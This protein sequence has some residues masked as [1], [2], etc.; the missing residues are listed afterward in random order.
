MKKYN[1]E[2]RPNFPK[3]AVITAGMPYG[4]KEL[5]F[6]HIGGVFIHADTFARFLR[7]RIGNENVIFVSGT[8]CYGSPILESYRKLMENDK[9][10][11][12]SIKDYVRKNHLHQKETLDRY[13]ISLNLYGASALDRPAEIHEEVSKDIFE[14]LYE[15]GCIEKMSTPQFYDREYDVLLNGRQVIGKCPIEGCNS[16]KG[17]A[18]EC[19]LGHQ[20]MPSEL[21]DPKSTLSGKTPEII[22]VENWYFKLE[23]YK[24]FLE[25]YVKEEREDSNTRKFILNIID[26]FLKQPV[27][28]V[29]KNQLTG[30]ESIIS[31]LPKHELIDEENKPSY[32]FIFDTLDDRDKAREVFAR[33]GVFI[34]TGKTLVPFRLSGNIEWGVKLPDKDGLKNLTFWV[35]P[36][37]LWAPISF[38]KAYLESNNKYDDEWKKW[39]MS[40]D[41]KVYQFIGEDN[42]YFYGIAEMAL[43]HGLDFKDEDGKTILPHLIANRHVLFLDKK[44]SSSG[45]IKPPMARELLDFYTPEQLRLHFLSLGLNN[46]S[47]SFNPQVYLPKEEQ[48]GMDVVLKDGNLLTNVFNRLVRSCFYTSAKYFDGIIPFGQVGSEMLNESENAILEY[49]RHMYNHEFHRIT[50]VLDSYVRYCNKYW[51]NQMRQADTTDNSELRKQVL[52]DCIHGV[53][54]A[55]LLFHPIAPVGCEK[56]REYL[57]IDERFWNWDYAFS[58]IYDLMPEEKN[59][60]IRELK[61]R[62]DFF[63]KHESQF[64]E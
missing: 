9:E 46:K 7:D 64:E 1:R 60:R 22:E 37:S 45:S 27:I 10:S 21:I 49:E 43:F 61:A 25:S 12:F 58:T 59:H 35:W 33:E 53:K 38:T 56:I 57:N 26:E 31:Q 48:A 4:N 5:H 15:K 55:A 29:K 42:I 63:V 23:E 8:D 11:S 41:S 2:S 39:W 62:E 19:S 20:Y 6:G 47:V 14:S 34:R 28:Y 44:A 54:T 17:Y 30:K 50:Y 3:R 52:I 24:D 16:D 32:T 13:Q 40:K 18:D 36:E 51:V